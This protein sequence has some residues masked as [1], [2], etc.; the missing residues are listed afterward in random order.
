[1]IVE[2]CFVDL[3]CGFRVRLFCW[4]LGCVLL[5]WLFV[6]WYLWFALVCFLL[7]FGWLVI[8]D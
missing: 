2:S 8:V 6:L 3:G 5:Y 4:M 7:G 1:M